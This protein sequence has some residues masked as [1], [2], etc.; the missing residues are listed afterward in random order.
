MLDAAMLG[1]GGS[2]QVTRAQCG[3]KEDKHKT[4]MMGTLFLPS[5]ACYNLCP[6]GGPLWRKKLFWFTEE[7]H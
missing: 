4:V 7:I 3:T 1:L 5:R 2:G 6:N